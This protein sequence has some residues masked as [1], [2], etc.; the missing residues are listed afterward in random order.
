M[1]FWQVLVGVAAGLAVQTAVAAA[2]KRVYAHVMDPRL[3]PDETRRAV[4][5][6]SRADFGNKL[7]FTSLRRLANADSWRQDLARYVDEAKLGNVIWPNVSM[8]ENEPRRLAEQVAELKRRNLW[9]FDLWGFVPGSGPGGP[10]RQFTLKPEVRD[11]FVREL[12]DRWLGMDVGE[13]DGRYLGAFAESQVPSPADRFA[14]Y[15]HFQRHFERMAELQG[16]RLAALVSCNF[17]H[18]L[19]RENV[20]TMIGAETA[21]AL[22][23][24]PI[25][26]SF[27]RGAGKQYGV[28]WFGNV[29]VYNR[30]GWKNYADEKPGKFGPEEGT[31]LSLLKRLMYS[32]IFYNTLL[33][34]FESSFFEKDGKTLS[35]I[36]RIQRG[37]IE[38]SERYGDP[39][40]QHAPI[41]VVIDAFGG[42]CVP[43]HLY[44]WQPYRVWGSLP[45]DAGDYFVDGVLDM[46]YPGYRD[47]SFFEDE[48]GFSPPTPYGDIADCLTSDAPLWVLKQYAVVILAGRLRPSRELEENVKAYVKDGGHVVLTGGNAAT[49]VRGTDDFAGKGRATRFNSEWGVA[50]TPQCELPV[51]YKVGA[52]L[53]T[54]YPLLADVRAELDRI[55]RHEMLFGTS[56]TPTNNGLSLVTCRRAKGEYT[57]AIANNTWEEKPFE[58]V[59]FVGPIV[60]VEELAVDVSERTARGYFPKGMEKTPLGR[61][62]DRTIAAGAIRTFRVKVA[63]TGVE[64]LPAAVPP[65]N[66]R[67]RVLALR[68]QTPIKEQVLAR[69]TFFRHFDGVMVDWSY[70]RARDVRELAAERKWLDRQGLKLVVD[71]SSGLNLYPDL[72]L[73]E[74]DPPETERSQAALKDLLAKMQA[75]GAKTLVIRRHRSPENQMDKAAAKAS[76][77]KNARR[78]CRDAAAK[79]IR[80]VVRGGGWNAEAAFRTAADIADANCSPAGSLATYHFEKRVPVDRAAA[81]KPA[82]FWFVAASATD[83]VSGMPHS[84]NLPVSLLPEKE[85]VAY[86]AAVKTL[87]EK[88]ATI[89]YDGNYADPEREYREVHLLEP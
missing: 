66:P 82:D 9:L 39:G 46:L 20:Y 3:H 37:A 40:V 50:K 25:Y 56:A 85:H 72:R 87:V 49:W 27:I 30:W 62:S 41:A 69:P 54:P 4:R 29:S 34:G 77:E 59:S 10:W 71:L 70:L 75:L 88:G 5:P 58:I 28:P 47:A 1:G 36:G 15:L 16:D 44:Q 81:T 22:P 32:Q 83:P 42:W 19:L 43:R 7:Q 78:L 74:N 61:D 21:Q 51:R 73:V 63:E 55:F 45:Y 67:G 14:A 60:S 6:P 84:F 76:F 11:L 52:D 23:S 35:P 80:V 33:C 38:W 24:S 31:S 26:Y 2:P 8:V 53:P 12:G 17:G 89:V 65:A 86:R 18:Y 48:R 64:E 13:Q 68:G 79:G 57:L